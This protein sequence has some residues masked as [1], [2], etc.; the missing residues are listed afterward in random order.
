MTLRIRPLGKDRFHNRYIYLDNV[1]VA[2]TH[3]SGRLYVNSPSDGDI[4]MMM[5]RDYV[6]DLPEQ[7]WGYGGG[8]WFIKRLM[9][10]QGFTEESTWLEHRM[11]EFNA[12]HASGYKGWW[13]YYSDPEE[14]S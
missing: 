5:E 10:D 12:G 14:V 8:R 4:Q 7:P 2:N 6:T 3:G 13:K 9:Q 11:N 1:G